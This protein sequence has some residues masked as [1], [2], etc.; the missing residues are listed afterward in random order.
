MMSQ[1]QTDDAMG[2][3]GASFGIG[4]SIGGGIGEGADTAALGAAGLVR[5][6]KRP[7][8][9]FN[10]PPGLLT[11]TAVGSFLDLPAQFGPPTGWFWDI[12]ALTAYGFTAGALAVTK[13]FPLVTA[14]GNPYAI[15]PVGAFTQAGVLTYSQHGMPLLDCTERLVWTVTSALTGQAQVSGTVIAVPAERISEYLS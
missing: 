12:A 11:A 3:I 13:N 14:A 1:Q 7:I 15:E 8:I 4:A 9:P 10:L 2:A 6:R 5:A